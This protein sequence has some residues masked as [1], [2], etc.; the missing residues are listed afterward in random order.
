MSDKK[1]NNTPK[2]CSFCGRDILAGEY[3]LSDEKSTVYICP[4]CA[5]AASSLYN[6]INDSSR[7]EGFEGTEPMEPPKS[8]VPDVD[9]L[10]YTTTSPKEIY[11]KFDEYVVG[12][13]RAKKKLSVALYN[14]IKRLC[15]ANRT[16]GKSNIMMCGPTGSGKTLLAKTIAKIINVPFAIADATSLTESGYV[17]DDVESVLNRLLD[18]AGGDIE[19]AQMGV[20]FIDEIDKISR[21][22]ENPSITKDVGGEGVQQALLKLIEGSVV[23]IPAHGAKR[24]NPTERNIPFDTSRV[25][26][27][28]G[29]AFEGI[30]EKC[31]TDKTC[32]FLAQPSAEVAQQKLITTTDLVKFG[33]IPEL[34]GRTPVLVQLDALTE[35]DLV[36]I[37]TVPKGCLVDEYKG[38]FDQDGVELEFE[39]EALAEI[40]HLAMENGTGAR[41]LRS[42]MEETLNDIMFEIPTIDDIYCCVI[43]QQTVHEHTLASAELLTPYGIF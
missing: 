38:L 34:V 12:Q 26:F 21:K 25:L 40:A 27:I 20:V 3:L 11:A 1:R 19:K 22:A 33:M 36:N 39:P 17:G 16:F 7:V 28:L 15:S 42:I 2:K 41:G 24:K 32:G 5:H 4:S 10:N 31:P 6:S 14:H 35:E 18:A 37:L 13:E 9:L 29:G 23:T 30:L 43:T 8:P